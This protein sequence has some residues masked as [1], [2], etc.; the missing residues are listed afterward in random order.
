[1][2]ISIAYDPKTSSIV[3]G[4]TSHNTNTADGRKAFLDDTHGVRT[5]VSQS[6]LIAVVEYM[7]DTDTPIRQIRMTDG[8]TVKFIFENTNNKG[9]KI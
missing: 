5:D 6:V 2:A 4:I 3:G 7:A 8:R 9:E 1:M